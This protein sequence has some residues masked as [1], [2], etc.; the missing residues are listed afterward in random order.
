MAEE[1]EVTREAMLLLNAQE[2]KEFSEIKVESHS[3]GKEKHM[4][5]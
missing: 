4:E 3:K 2:C 1:E 5:R